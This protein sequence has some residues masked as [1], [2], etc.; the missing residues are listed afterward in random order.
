MIV[1][2]RF[3]RGRLVTNRKGKNGQ[4]AR[5]LA[6][7]L[8]LVAISFAIF[9]FWR[10]GQDLDILGDFVFSTGLLSHWQVWIAAAAA[11]QYAVWWLMRYSKLGAAGNSEP[12]TGESATEK[13]AV[14]AS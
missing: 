4:A 5:V 8:S 2:I 6:S 3:G 1:R 12:K 9:G 14:R 13:A 10:L 7:L 11:T